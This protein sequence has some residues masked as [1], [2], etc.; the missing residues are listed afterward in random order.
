MNDMIRN[1]ALQ[2][3]MRNQNVSNTPMGKEFIDIL[4][5]GDSARGE[6]LADNLCQTY[7]YSRE[8]ALNQ[9]KEY[10]SSLF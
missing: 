2:L 10:F 4:R 8:D 3:M 7:G 6:Q 1:F 9:A 5:S